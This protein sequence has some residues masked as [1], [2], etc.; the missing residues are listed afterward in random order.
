MFISSKVNKRDQ[1][2][3]DRPSHSSIQVEAEHGSDGTVNIDKMDGPG[4]SGDG[5]SLSEP[6]VVLYPP[7]QVKLQWGQVMRKIGAGLVNQ[8]NTC[9]MNSVLQC[10]THTP[11]LANYCI[12]DEHPKTCT[13]KKFCLMC[14]FTHHIRNALQKGASIIRPAWVSHK[15]VIAKSFRDGRQEDAHEFLRVVV[16]GLQKAC[17]NGYTKLD[18]LS[19]ET[20]VVN[21][22]FGGYLQ[23]Q[24]R[25]MKCSARFNTYD[26]YMDISLD[27]KDVKTL[28]EAFSRFVKPEMLDMD[29]AY[30][31][32]RCHQKVNAEKR[33]S[34]HRASNVL[35]IQL[36]RF[37]Y[38]GA[39]AKIRKHI[40]FSDR[41]NIRPYMSQV[42]GESVWYHLYG[43]LIHSGLD[44]M[45]GHYYCYVKNPSNT[46]YLMNDGRVESVSPHQVFRDE[47][48]VLF[49]LRDK[50]QNYQSQNNTPYNGPVNKGWENRFKGAAKG[51]PVNRAPGKYPAHGSSVN[52]TPAKYTAG[53]SPVNGT[54][55]KYTP[56]STPVNGG[57]GKYNTGSSPVNG[58]PGKYSTGSSPVNGG[59]GKYSGRSNGTAGKHTPSGSPVTGTAPTHPA[60]HP[61][62]IG[63]VRE[64]GDFCASVSQQ[65]VSPRPSQA[66]A[67]TSASAATALPQQ[68]KKISFDFNQKTFQPVH[69]QVPQRKDSATSSSPAKRIVMHIKNGKVTTV[70]KSSD[71]KE[72][73]VK[74]SPISK[75]PSTLVPYDLDSDSGGEG[76]SKK[77]EW[78]PSRNG[79]TVG[80]T[81]HHQEQEHHSDKCAKFAWDTRT[82]SD[83]PTTNGCNG[84]NGEHSHIEESEGV[85]KGEEWDSKRSHDV[86]SESDRNHKEGEKAFAD[87]ESAASD[88]TSQTHCDEEESSSAVP[89][90]APSANSGDFQVTG[91]GWDKD[92]KLSQ[93][94]DLFSSSVSSDRH[95]RSG[96]VDRN[97]MTVKLQKRSSSL[98]P[99]QRHTEPCVDNTD[100]I[101]D[102]FSKRTADPSDSEHVLTCEPSSSN[103]DVAPEN[104]TTF[105]QN[106]DAQQ[107]DHQ[108]SQQAPKITLSLNS[109]GEKRRKK[110]K[111]KKHRERYHEQDAGTD[112]GYR[113]HYRKKK[114]RHDY[115]YSDSV[116]KDSWNRAQDNSEY[117]Y[118][119]K[120]RSDV[121]YSDYDYQSSS[122][123]RR[124]SESSDSEYV[125]EE[126]TKESLLMEKSAV[127]EQMQ[128]NSV[129]QYGRDGD[130]SHA[131]VKPAQSERYCNGP[132]WSH[133]D[134]REWKKH[135]DQKTWRSTQGSSWSSGQRYQ[136]HNGLSRDRWRENYDSQS[137]YPSQSYNSCPMPGPSRPH[138]D[139]GSSFHRS[140]SSH[141]NRDHH[142]HSGF[143]GSHYY[144][145]H[146]SYGYQRRY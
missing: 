30:K 13:Q 123:K 17:L 94:M 48:Y 62:G 100:S 44:S 69:S 7:H 29:N 45:C 46:W 121:R 58:G 61:T 129:R 26:P 21:Q 65:G 137:S 1:E 70:E 132:S 24:V 79:S 55:G 68:R 12:S 143:S 98:E 103:H 88:V 105:A 93:Y 41:L 90:I 82:F 14:E 95:A 57:P 111:R 115:D 139:Q 119:H 63:V 8:G 135:G 78:E 124:R 141:Y 56:H 138:T 11:P 89:P 74:S 72:S 117:D 18:R 60:H 81:S 86:L 3:G 2:R 47:A 43:V 80:E 42:Q 101:H 77:S 15:N 136:N 113:H 104:S 31:C 102:L 96:S 34:I 22:I 37:D 32:E 146:R 53:T 9:Y 106:T 25:C 71:G 120:R 130:R 50:H 83:S 6:C 110:K 35:T 23:S 126:K 38:I 76:S 128:E 109:S 107:T 51:S 87:A 64:S 75:G 28:E 19:K 125:W 133:N 20:T 116:H 33:L 140:S 39:A 5:N 91:A 131:S 99:V 114:H 145:S 27:L 52:G 127:E 36:K 97:S 85:S 10:L 73:L 92:Y 144:G 84:E 142:N 40:P 134:T 66:A 112:D 54:P 59:P 108:D 4:P 49:Y 118:K 67:S 16:D 122:G